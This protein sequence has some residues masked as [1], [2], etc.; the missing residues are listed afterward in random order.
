M[1]KVTYMDFRNAEQLELNFALPPTQE[2]TK[3]APKEA[4]KEELPEDD[5]FLGYYGHVYTHKGLGDPLGIVVA[6]TPEACVSQLSSKAKGHPS[7]ASVYHET[8]CMGFGRGS[9]V[10]RKIEQRVSLRPHVEGLRPA[11]VRPS[12]MKERYVV[13]LVTTDG[14]V[15]VVDML[16]PSL[17]WVKFE[18]I[19]HMG[20]F[21]SS[22]G[23][24]AY[25]F[26]LMGTGRLRKAP[27]MTL[28]RAANEAPVVVEK[29][30]ASFVLRNA[31][32]PGELWEYAAHQLRSLWT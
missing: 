2:T 31:P 3:E 20:S 8:L 14:G 17:R 4:P 15:M 12:D 24:L 29:S 28:Y 10:L 5:I 19:R 16:A 21:D 7:S 1:R 11:P 18:V 25:V 22:T 32:K 23:M 30:N 9:Y 26:P 6:Q 27:A 13:G